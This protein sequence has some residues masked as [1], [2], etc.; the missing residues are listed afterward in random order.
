MV[1]IVSL[2]FFFF[3]V[4]I[5][6]FNTLYLLKWIIYSLLAFLGNGF[7][8]VIQKIQQMNFD[9]L[10]KS[11]FMIVTLLLLSAFIYITNCTVQKAA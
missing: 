1:D 2:S 5:E 3:K 9:G 8:S 11:E 6:L 7:C 10:Y 4:C